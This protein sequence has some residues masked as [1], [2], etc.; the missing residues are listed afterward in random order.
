MPIIDGKAEIA[1]LSEEMQP[2]LLQ[3]QQL[4]AKRQEIANRIVKFQGAIELLQRL[5]GSKG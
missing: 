4:D 2:L 5:D 1:K 3:L